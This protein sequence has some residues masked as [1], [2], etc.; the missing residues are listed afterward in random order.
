MDVDVARTLG[1]ALA[2][3]VLVGAERY[4]GRAPGEVSFA[5]P[6]TFAAIG[7]LGGVCAV[8]EQVAF[9]VVTFAAVAVLV[10]IAYARDSA[11]HVGSTTE[12]A[13]LLTFWLGYLTRNYETAAIG[14]GIVLAILLASKR[15][16]HDFV[17]G[18]ISETEFSDTLKF[19]AVVFVI[20]PLLPDR[21]V[22]PYGFFNPRQAWTFV[23]LFSF[24]GYAGYF[25]IRV[26]GP[27]RGL[28]GSAL[29]G[30]LASTPALTVSMAHRARDD[31]E[32]YRMISAAA[33]L[34]NAVQFPRLLLLL[35]I[36][37]EAL[38]AFIAPMLITMLIVGVAVAWVIT[39]TA[40]KSDDETGFEIQLRNP[41]SFLPALRFAG[42][43]VAFLLLSRVALAY[44][45]EGGVQLMA[46]LTGLANVSVIALSLPE[47]TNEGG[48][49]ASGAA[50]AL[51]LAIATN[52]LTKWLLALLNGPRNMA[53]WLGAGLA[54]MVAAGAAYLLMVA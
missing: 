21:G 20:Y 16:L 39:L 23:V 33:V 18:K 13:V 25:L 46:G 38:A 36:V 41:F 12:V 3:G 10:A 49:P 6:R 24:I 40:L 11:E 30:G 53:W 45:G 47:L 19:L 48:L 43:L 42:F 9:A 44:W 32:H 14:A 31:P 51:L 8:T 54:S 50:A 34:G 37:D 4:R 52:A 29:M 1:E 27:G 17:R 7:L 28:L 22:G 15:P 5:G 26:V 2:I 35:L